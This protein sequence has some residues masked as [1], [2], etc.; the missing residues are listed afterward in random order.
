MIGWGSPQIVT[1]GL[2][3]HLDAANPKSYIGSGTTWNDISGRRNNGTLVNGP[4]FDSGNGG[5]I[6]FDGVDDY[7]T[8]IGNTSTFSFINSLGIFT[9]NAWVRLE[10]PLSTSAHYI[11]GNNSTTLGERGFNIG[12][13]GTSGRIRFT[14]TRGSSVLGATIILQFDNY[15]T[16]NLWNYVT[17]TGN[18]NT[19]QVYRNGIPFQTPQN[20]GTF[21]SGDAQ[22]VLAVGRVNNTTNTYWQGNIT[23]TTIYNRALTQQEIL[24]NYNATKSRFGL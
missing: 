10:N 23:Q 17:I 6:V 16:N 8:N 19:C 15:F 11:M 20:L 3:L 24:Q 18:G 7:V 2:V 14:I 13:T 5:S 9:I 22:R 1:D 4:T 12:F 21:T